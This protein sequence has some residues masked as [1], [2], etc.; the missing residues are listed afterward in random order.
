MREGGR[1]QPE[2]GR[3]GTSR[4]SRD[5]HVVPRAVP[6][7][8]SRGRGGKDGA[9]RGPVACP[10]HLRGTLGDSPGTLLQRDVCV[11]R[12]GAGLAQLLWL[13][14]SSKPAGL[15]ASSE[16]D[17]YLLEPLQADRCSYLCCSP[18]AV[19]AGQFV[20]KAQGKSLGLGSLSLR[21]LSGSLSLSLRC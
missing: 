1:Q 16:R 8:P 9:A 19:E 5:A 3:D 2:D 13:I 20:A 7:T 4:E 15:S 6:P 18:S 12:L 10:G 11:P 17:A 14:P 21:L